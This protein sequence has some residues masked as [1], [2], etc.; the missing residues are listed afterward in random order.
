MQHWL[1]DP[2]LIYPGTSMPANFATEPAQYQDQFP[3]STNE[4][5]ILVVLE[6]LYNFDRVTIS[7]AQ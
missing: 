1:E 5:Q 6:W 7:G 2:S 3:D 4:D